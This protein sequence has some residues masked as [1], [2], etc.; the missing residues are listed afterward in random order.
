MSTS[1]WYPLGSLIF[2]FLNVIIVVMH[3]ESQV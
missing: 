1:K 3:G 2:D